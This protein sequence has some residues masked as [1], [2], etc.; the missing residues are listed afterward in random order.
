[1]QYCMSLFEMDVILISND[2]FSHFASRM[3]G[4]ELY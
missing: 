1:M 2:L 4:Q 3:Y